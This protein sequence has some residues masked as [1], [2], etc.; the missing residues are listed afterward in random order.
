VM[1]PE[2]FPDTVCQIF[3]VGHTSLIR[4]NSD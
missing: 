4:I 2:Y 1:I 3:V